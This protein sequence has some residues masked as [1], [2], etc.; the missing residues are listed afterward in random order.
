[1]FIIKKK[2]GRE[3]TKKTIPKGILLLCTLFLGCL[4]ILG[5]FLYLSGSSSRNFFPVYEE[6]YSVSSD[7]NN[8]IGQVDYTIYDS[9]FQWGVDEKD[10]FFPAVKPCHEKGYEWDFTELV[11]KLS[12]KNS[13]VQ[14]KKI[15]NNGLSKIKPSVS[16][17]SVKSGGE[18][19]CQIFTLGLYTHKIR[20]VHEGYGDKKH[21]RLPK[22]AIVI[23]DMGYD[24]N[25]ANSF[26][27]MDLPLTL[28]VLP[29]APFTEYVASEANKR[30]I[31]LLLHMPMEPK[32]Y[33]RLNPGPGALLTDMNE[34]EIREVITALLGQ[35]PNLRG[36]NHHMGSYFTERSDKMTSVLKELKEHN[37]FYVDSRT[38]VHTVAYKVAKKLGV[39]VTKKSVF[40]DHYLSQKA[41]KIQM[42]RLLGMARYSG[43]AVGIGHPHKQTL[44]VLHEYLHRLKTDFKVVPVSE[45]V[46]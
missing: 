27:Q 8:K 7:L 5:A 43:T 23:D 34:A 35:V 26:I 28:S 21:K 25:L 31:E 10:I 16:I 6:I 46:G 11:I 41:I 12:N 33:P 32:G 38:T 2:K 36:V 42:E 13:A 40:L 37:L 14:L 18:V 24:R 17:N 9:L 3:K 1:M 22:I 4:I 20:L 19:V 29:F 15:I 44:K 45:L 39:P 30:G